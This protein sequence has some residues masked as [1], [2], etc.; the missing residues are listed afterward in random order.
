MANDTATKGNRMF[1]KHAIAMIFFLITHHTSQIFEEHQIQSAKVSL[2]PKKWAQQNNS[3]DIPHP[4][5]E[6]K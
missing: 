2:P 6:Y 1:W 5:C 4:L 3:N